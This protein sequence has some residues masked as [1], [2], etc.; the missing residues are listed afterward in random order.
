MASAVPPAQYLPGRR[1]CPS[2]RVPPPAARSACRV[3]QAIMSMLMT[4]LIRARSA[5]LRPLTYW[6][7]PNRPC[8]SPPNRIKPQ[9]VLR[10]PARQRPGDGQHAGAAGRIVVRTRRGSGEPSDIHGIQVRSDQHQVTILTVTGT[11]S[12]EVSACAARHRHGLSA[13]H[14]QSGQPV[15]RPLQTP[16]NSVL[17]SGACAGG[18]AYRRRPRMLFG[19]ARR[20]RCPPP[21]PAAPAARTRQPFDQTPRRR[22]AGGSPGNRTHASVGGGARG[23]I[24]FDHQ[25][26]ALVHHHPNVRM[27]RLEK[28]GG[29][30]DHMKMPF[31][32]QQ[33]IGR[34]SG[35]A[36]GSGPVRGGRRGSAPQVRHRA[37]SDLAPAA[38]RRFNS[39]S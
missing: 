36:A 21:R 10:W 4:A 16:R 1:S 7:L 8:S 11:V 30:G 23:R 38:R 2:T 27:V 37:W 19:T 39:S 3:S 24:E 31:G 25:V 6:G 12:N 20:R 5:A 33:A 34:I 15:S 18:Q 35:S 26:M 32:N 28:S 14:I 29:L 9:V 17:R 22:P 13:W